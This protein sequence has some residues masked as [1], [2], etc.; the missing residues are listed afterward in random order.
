MGLLSTLGVD[1]IIKQV[2]ETA[3]QVLPNNESKREFQIKLEELRDRLAQREH[4]EIMAQSETNKIEAAHASI[5][6]AGWRPAIGWTCAIG[7]VW[8]FGLA[9][10]LMTFGLKPGM[11]P[12]EHLMALTAAMLGVSGIRSFDLLKG[13]ARDSLVGSRNAAP[14][15]M[16]VRAEKYGL[17]GQQVLDDQTTPVPDDRSA[18]WNR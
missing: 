11:L 4:E 5:F 10:A 7:C 16:A 12:I 3:R 14:V 2:G 15:S 18:P 6:V 17:D 8:N 1:E 13:V 9:P